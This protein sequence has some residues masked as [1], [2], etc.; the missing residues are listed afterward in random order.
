MAIPRPR[1]FQG[2]LD[3][4][5]R[6]SRVYQPVAEGGSV[7]QNRQDVFQSLKVQ[8]KDC[9]CWNCLVSLLRLGRK[10]LLLF[11]VLLFAFLAPSEQQC[12]QHSPQQQDR[13]SKKQN[14]FPL[15]FIHRRANLRKFI[16]LRLKQRKERG[17][18]KAA[19]LIVNAVQRR[20]ISSSPP[21]A[22]TS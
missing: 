13:Q 11:L 20:F 21:L 2:A 4:H 3:S 5:Q 8:N 17:P 7:F 1:P 22:G 19:L 15:S 14:Y 16:E 9:I 6:G 12:Q 10:L 18:E